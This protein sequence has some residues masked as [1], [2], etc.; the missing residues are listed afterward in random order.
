[1]EVGDLVSKP[2]V[3]LDRDGTI[4]VDHGY[5][6]EKERLEL[7]PGAATA[8]GDLKRA[9]FMIVVV[10]NQSA[11][12]RGMATTEE[13]EQTNVE[14][15]RMLLEIDED[16]SLDVVLFCA[17]HPDSA[18]DRRKPGCGMLRELP[19]SMSFDPEVS[20]MI[21]DKV[22]DIEFGLNAG[23]DANSG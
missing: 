17:D 4:N 13:V 19:S 3:F 5:V 6:F 10:S 16:A 12:G 8:I 23:I 21:G 9:G 18:T 2:I 22:S 11:V 15:Q 20:W 1:M 14:L 7:I